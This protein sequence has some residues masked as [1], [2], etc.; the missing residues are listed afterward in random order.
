MFV[1]AAALCLPAMAYNARLAN[2]FQQAVKDR[3]QE[4]FASNNE[5]PEV[6][7]ANQQERIDGLGKC[8]VHREVM[9]GLKD[10]RCKACPGNL[11]S[12]EV[13]T[14]QSYAAASHYVYYVMALEDQFG[15]ENVNADR[16]RRQ[17]ED[18]WS[19]LRDELFTLYEEAKLST[20]ETVNLN[21]LCDRV[22][23]EIEAIDDEVREGL[24]SSA[25]PAD[26]GH[27]YE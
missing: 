1:V 26:G 10:K 9:A 18:S 2:E 5:A 7:T 27:F 12:P 6:R 3:Y 4:E 23:E 16:L 21:S 11:P 14:L 25:K 13:L 19:A 22:V 15:I 8:A 24:K 20:P 17:L